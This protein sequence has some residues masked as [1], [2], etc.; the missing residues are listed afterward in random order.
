MRLVSTLLVLVSGLA[1]QMPARA[2][3]DARPVLKVI[4]DRPEAVYQAGETAKFTVRLTRDGQPVDGEISWQLS[5]DGFKTL[6]EGQGA[7]SQSFSGTLSAPGVLRATVTYRPTGQPPVVAHAGAVFDPL[8]IEPS[9]PAPDDFDAFWA[10]QKKQ[11]AE[12]PIAARQTAVKSPVPDVEC[13]DTQIDCLGDNPVSGYFARPVKAAPRSLPAVL[14]VHGAGVRSSQLQAAAGEARRGRLALD[15]NAHGIPNGEPAEFYEGLSRGALSGYR[16]AGREDREKCYFREMFVRL[17]R[18]IDYLCAQ[19]EWDGEIVI[20]RGA[21]QG[22]GQALAAAG[23]DPRVT[24]IYAGVPALCD[25]SG[26]AIGRIAGWPKLVPL[27][28]EGKP[29]DK[30]L[31]VARYFDGMNFATR[32]RADAI[33]SVGFIDATCPPT[34][35][36]ATYNALRGR[37]TMVTGPLSGHEGPQNLGPVVDQF[38]NEHIQRRQLA[39]SNPRAALLQTFVDEF[40]SITPGQ[41][42]F[43]AS[44]DM[45]SAADPSEQPVHKVTLA[46]PFA[47]ARYEVTQN[48]YEAVMGANPSRWKG[49]RNSVE[50]MSWNEART[51]CDKATAMLRS[52]NLIAA[53][54]EIRLPTEA[55]WE[56]CC[57]AGTKTRYSFGDEARKADEVDHY[58]VFLVGAGPNKIGLIKAVREVTDLGLKEAK[59]LVESLP[60]PIVRGV[61]IEEAKRVAGLLQESGG[62]PVV[63]PVGQLNQYAWHHG[64][65]AGNDPPV[66]ALKPNAWGLYDMHGYLWE[67]TADGWSR[68]YSNAT[69]DGSAVPANERIVLRSGSWK[70]NAE[71]L[72]STTR[73]AYS[74]TDADDAVGFRCV[75][76]KVR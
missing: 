13:F 71:K 25:H 36:Y 68:D 51:F 41:G 69:M 66:G 45:G 24:A 28:P 18:A 67:F 14:F 21:S 9:L 11:L 58:D 65:A 4:T 59:D 63:R 64:N 34:S 35:V 75:R 19:P 57:R 49:P 38:L 1:W 61:A 47:M 3:A 53:D 48:L 31:N 56:Y 44:F 30:I 22:G 46:A 29:D 43:P 27:T 10:D 16:H 54:E 7:V 70:D 23:L 72:T 39:R 17:V 5:L 60:R 62:G 20:V 55:E 50:M 12:I 6:E 33:V 8:G 32:T 42:V 73:R 40:V 37:K 76:S 74:V 2:Q 26:N 15:I 52:E